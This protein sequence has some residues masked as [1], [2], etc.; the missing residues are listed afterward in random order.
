MCMFS[1]LHVYVTEENFTDLYYTAVLFASGSQIF[2]YHCVWTF[3]FYLYSVQI[4]A[5]RFTDMR[6]VLPQVIL[7]VALIFPF[8]LPSSK[9]QIRTK[10]GSRVQIAGSEPKQKVTQTKG[11][12]VWCKMMFWEKKKLK[13]ISVLLCF[14]ISLVL[15]VYSDW[16][17]VLFLLYL[18]NVN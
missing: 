11:L 16:F 10:V 3:L 2:W 5:R 9:Y 8:L 7:L 14:V 13:K 17:L 18:R 6:R 4:C 15:L 1:F 12:K